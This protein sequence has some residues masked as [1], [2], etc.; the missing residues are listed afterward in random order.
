M[1]D[2][3]AASPDHYD[4]FIRTYPDHPRVK[5]AKLRREH[6][7]FVQAREK[8]TAV[9]CD[10]YLREYPE[11]R[12][13]EQ[14]QAWLE[15]IWYRH[16]GKENNVQLLES[17]VRR[18]PDGKYLPEI[19]KHLLY[20]AE[21]A[22]GG[23]D[24][25]QAV[26]YFLLAQHTPASGKKPAWDFNASTKDQLVSAYTVSQGRAL[27]RVS[28]VPDAFMSRCG[29]TKDDLRK[30]CVRCLANSDF[31]IQFEA[32]VALAEIHDAAGKDVLLTALRRDYDLPWL[33]EPKQQ[34]QLQ[35][36]L[37]T[38]AAFCLAVLREPAAIDHLIS[39]AE[40]RSA[41]RDIRAS[42]VTCLRQYGKDERAI[43]ALKRIETSTAVES[44]QSADRPSP[45][46]YGNM[47]RQ[48]MRLE[49]QREYEEALKAYT[50]IIHLFPRVPMAYY[51]RSVLQVKLGRTDEATAG[52]YDTLKRTRD[53]DL[54][55]RSYLT[56][57]NAYAAAKDIGKAENAYRNALALDPQSIL[58][59]FNLGALEMNERGD[60][61]KAIDY[62]ERVKA[63]DV[64]YPGIDGYI[65][66]ARERG[67][68][69][70]HGPVE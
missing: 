5:E 17:F 21:L 63:I 15:D 9:T 66:H 24:Y 68:K 14:V 59:L 42:A 56:L 67:E 18:F 31:R 53:R 2:H 51:Q 47:L 62:W 3:N 12:Y 28:C 4:Y 13:A 49:Q 32:A 44:V 43:A 30:G 40:S 48:A 50:K 19:G 37:A 34:V 45:E 20:L 36:E 6:L 60:H 35:D 8:R 1:N 22:A 52:L 10:A 27:Q 69:Q 16:V 29:I 55:V 26:R 64:D 61:R 33:T 7:Y 65:E 11:G 54:R 41:S 46:D 38:I 57:G 23:G 58:A 70:G 25:P 39:L